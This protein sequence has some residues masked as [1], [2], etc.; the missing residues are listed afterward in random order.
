MM[1]HLRHIT[2]SG[3]PG[4]SVRRSRS[5]LLGSVSWGT[6]ALLAVSVISVP[7]TAEDDGLGGYLS[8]TLDEAVF[9]SATL[10]HESALDLNDGNG[11][12]VE[13]ILQP[14][15]EI[16]LPD[17]LSLTAIGRARWDVRDRLEPGSPSQ[18]STATISRRWLAS[19]DV[20]FELREFYVD[21]PTS[22]AHFRIGKQQTVWGQA[23]GLKVL[24]VVNPQDFREFILDD[25]EDS[26]IPL[27]TFAAE[28]PV[29]DF[30][31]EFLWIPDQTY[32]DLPEADA[33]YALTAPRFVPEAI[34][35]F[36]VIQREPDRPDDIIA[37]S[38]AGARLLGMVDGWDFSLNYLFHYDDNPVLRRR[39][40]GT[41]VTI[42]PVYERTHLLGGTFS[43]SFGDF[44]LRGELGYSFDRFFLTDDPTDSDG[45]EESDNVSSVI[46]LDWNGLDDTFVS[47][48]IFGDYLTNDINGLVR[49]QFEATTSL[50][51][52][53]SFLDEDLVAEV[54]W[55]QSVNS[56]D[57]LIRPKI[58]YQV[59]DN[60]KLWAG[61]DIFFGTSDGVFGQFN[62]NDRFLFGVQF[63]F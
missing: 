15:L 42:N 48:Q 10:T 50:L 20:D 1:T 21:A 28:V 38:D 4:C 54:I 16:E 40:Q 25:F 14:E 12:K 22:F 36:T 9:F 53:R 18:D 33:L 5:A 24:D 45:V 59:D 7:V 8:D 19:D 26:R 17:G 44:V 47:A 52:R 41:T 51:V 58:T 63:S 2:S 55:L 57:G 3:I 62:D 13:T 34:P 37:D 23:D 46:G 49:D 29:D 6:A 60:V 56:G 11:Q 35:G 31:A 43:N 39:V 32:N 61:A 27:W 30:M